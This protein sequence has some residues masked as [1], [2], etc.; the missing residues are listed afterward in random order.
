MVLTIHRMSMPRFDSANFG[1]HEGG[2]YRGRMPAPY[3]GLCRPS[4][5]AGSAVSGWRR[6]SGPL[7][8]QGC[9]QA[10]SRHRLDEYVFVL[11]VPHR[12]RALAVLGA[13][14][15]VEAVDRRIDRDEG[16]RA[17]VVAARGDR[18]VPRPEVEHRRVV[19]GA[20]PEPPE[21]LILVRGGELRGVVRSGRDHQA[22]TPFGAI[23][24][25]L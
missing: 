21:R 13:D 6:P 5:T 25:A 15:E 10:S 23:G 1:A 9:S 22:L 7:V 18:A 4:P 12:Q 11:T 8:N 3:Q 20:H 2:P 14:H 19:L 17:V 24:L 16:R